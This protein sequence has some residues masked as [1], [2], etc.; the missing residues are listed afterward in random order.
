MKIVMNEFDANDVNILA[1]LCRE[2]KIHSVSI[3][4]DYDW[5]PVKMRPLTEE[6]KEKYSEEFSE[7][8]MPD[9]V[10]DCVMPDDGQQ[11][12]ISTQWSD[13]I[14]MDVC[15][16]DPDY[17]IGLEERGDWDGVL[18]WMPVPKKYKQEGES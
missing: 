11:V 8:E 4:D 5:R 10:F 3:T 7:D 9:G 15:T 18:A 17:G 12:L 2:G 16:R 6:E 1:K 14:D 13:E